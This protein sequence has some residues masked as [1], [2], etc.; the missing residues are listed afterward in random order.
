MDT[1]LFLAQI[2]GPIVL[3]LGLGIFLSRAH[4]A[5]IYRNL[6]NEPLAILVFA[7]F[8][9]AFGIVQVMTHNVWGTLPQIIVTLFGWGLLLKGFMLALMP[10]FAE[11]LGDWVAD[12]KLIYVG[13]GFM[14]IV[15]A[16][17][18]WFGFLG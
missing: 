3:A 8:G 11:G 17:L 1:T 18:T 7:L 14:L 5:R 10:R 6:E 12:S 4:Y 9:I 16:Y 15:G 2:W 13:G